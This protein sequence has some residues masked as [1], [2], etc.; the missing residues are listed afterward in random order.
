MAAAELA[1]QK[2]LAAMTNHAKQVADTKMEP[3]G[4]APDGQAFQA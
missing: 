1:T 3:A 4:R 2:E